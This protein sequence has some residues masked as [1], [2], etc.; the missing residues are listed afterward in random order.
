V[1]RHRGLERNRLQSFLRLA[2]PLVRSQYCKKI[3]TSTSFASTA[4]ICCPKLNRPALGQWGIPQLWLDFHMDIILGYWSREVPHIIDTR[5]LHIII[6]VFANLHQQCLPK[7][8][9]QFSFLT[10]ARILL[11]GV[12]QGPGGCLTDHSSK[13]SLGRL[14]PCRLFNTPHIFFS[15]I[16]DW[17]IYSL[18]KAYH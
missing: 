6:V 17:R 5:N 2:I 13:D 4:H 1:D 10:I 12:I 7:S 3:S 8:R 15:S 9:H 16:A 11:S 18:G 14:Q